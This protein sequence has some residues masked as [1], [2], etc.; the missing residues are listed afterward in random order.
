M[1]VRSIV[2]GCTVALILVG[3]CSAPLAHGEDPA[4]DHRPVVTDVALHEGGVLYG[5]VVNAEAVAIPNA[6]VT[7]F[8]QGRQVAATRTDAAGRFHFT[9]I[10]AGV[11]QLTTPLGSGQ[12]RLWAPRT[13][14]PVAQAAIVVVE[15]AVVRGQNYGHHRQGCH[16][17]CHPAVRKVAIAT[18]VGIGIAGA[19]IAIDYN[20]P[21][22]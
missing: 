15:D 4:A 17:L 19:V 22:S 13:A 11:Y 8:Q 5:Q 2:A 10:K 12:Y 1:K 16:V 18:G 14:P 21:G 9:G 7:L 3:L 6:E 20:E